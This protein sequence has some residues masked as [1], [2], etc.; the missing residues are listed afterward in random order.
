MT[1]ICRKNPIIRHIWLDEKGKPGYNL[2]RLSG[3]GNRE[4]SYG[5]TLVGHGWASRFSGWAS[6]RSF[7]TWVERDTLREHPRRHELTGM[8]PFVHIAAMLTKQQQR[9]ITAVYGRS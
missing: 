2:R 8:L 1:L 5:K 9:D 7:N 3:S 4:S 6:V